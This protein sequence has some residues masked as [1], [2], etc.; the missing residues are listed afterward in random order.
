MFSPSAL[1]GSV[2]LRCQIRVVTR[3]APTL[4]AATQVRGRRRQYASDATTP[5][6]EDVPAVFEARVHDSKT[7]QG[8]DET[9]PPQPDEPSPSVI[10][11]QTLS[12]PQQDNLGD[13]RLGP[14]RSATDDGN[15]DA[16]ER[17]AGRD[18]VSR[19]DFDPVE[20]ALTSKP[21][22]IIQDGTGAWK[23]NQ[24]Q[25]SSVGQAQQDSTSTTAGALA[26]RTC[27]Q[28]RKVFSSPAG[29][30]DHT[31]QGCASLKPPRHLECLKCGNI[32]ATKKLLHRHLATSPCS[33]RARSQ[34]LAGK[35]SGRNVED[36]LTQAAAAFSRSQAASRGKLK[37]V[38]DWDLPRR[39]DVRLQAAPADREPFK[40]TGQGAAAGMEDNNL[41]KTEI[42]DDNAG[43]AGKNPTL[44]MSIARDRDMGNQRR[45]EDGS[46]VALIRRIGKV[47]PSTSGR[48]K[49]HRRG[50]MLLVEDASKLGIESLGKAAEVIVLRDGRQWERKTRPV[51]ASSEGTTDE[52]LKIEDWL[53]EQGVLSLDDVVKNIHGLKPERRIVSAREYKSL[54]NTLFDGFTI[55]QLENYVVWHREQPIL[56]TIKDEVF[57]ETKTASEEPAMPADVPPEHRHYAWMAE[58]AHWTPHVDGAVEDAQYPLAGYIMKSMPPKQRLVVQLMRECW[59]ISIQEL[60]NGNGRVDIRVRDL[61]FKLLTLGS[62]SWLRNL[63][64]RFLKEGQQIEVRRSSNLIRIT[65]PKTVAE[66]CVNRLGD[67]L[68]KS[69]TRTLELDRI[70]VG[71][72]DAST[73]EELGGITNSIVH[74][75]PGRKTIQV[76]WIDVWDAETQS[77]FENPGDQVFRL[78][79]TASPPARTWSDLA[80]YPDVEGNG[81]L[82]QDHSNK[83]KFPWTARRSEWARLC[84]PLTSKQ[85]RAANAWPPTTE[86]LRFKVQPTEEDLAVPYSTYQR[87]VDKL[88]ET[89]SPLGLP[90]SEEE[91]SKGQTP[92]QEPETTRA[93]PSGWRPF[94]IT[95]KAAFGHVLHLGGP[96]LAE[97]ITRPHVTNTLAKWP[98]IFAPLMPHVAEMALPAWSPYDEGVTKARALTVLMRFAPYSEDAESAIYTERA[99]PLELRLTADDLEIKGVHSLRAINR[100]SISDILLP[101]EHVDVR[102]TQQEYAELSPNIIDS[103]EGMEPLREFLNKSRFDLRKGKLNTPPRLH[104]L[105]LPRWLLAP[106]LDI[107]TTEPSSRADV[108]RKRAAAAAQPPQ[109]LPHTPEGNQIRNASYVFA[110]LEFR[111]AVETTYDGWKLVYTSI[112]GGASGGRRAELSLEAV[113]GYDKDLRRAKEAINA[114][115]FLRSIYQLATGQPGHLVRRADGEEQVRTSISWVR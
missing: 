85:Q 107:A 66:T 92:V 110:G 14:D 1:G 77:T 91:K 39:E 75:G 98:R 29:R 32:F 21:E 61:E 67:T 13:A 6:R 86:I 19:A 62:Q 59:D 63:S 94:K 18:Q 104:N 50:D 25:K 115:F 79:L 46:P 38:D 100:T 56:E 23:T 84:L 103:I 51:A 102:T 71:H 37:V 41:G 22:H 80:V 28:C 34:K 49:H 109:N 54:F 83:E 24:I 40:S 108:K 4:L 45:A 74:F 111:Y 78:L 73:L 2:C 93:T 112:E 58:E 7:E 99:P 12:D 31:R 26:N 72:L 96:K 70:P 81:R 35:D 97:S 47:D 33:G 87:K 105:G 69:K 9:R 17:H 90:K 82:I 11:K 95:T 36:I 57:G 8:P 3:R 5:Q 65:A 60:L 20:S 88:D 42:L 43:A 27:P 30:D 76:T 89:V 101:A 10:P 106:P 44:Q 64:R 55:A 68:Q 53:E 16:I 15:H 48:K 113:P 52:G 114:T